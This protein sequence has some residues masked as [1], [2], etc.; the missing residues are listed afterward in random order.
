MEEIKFED[1]YGMVKLELI[2]KG[3]TDKGY[4]DTLELLMDT[5]LINNDFNELEKIDRL[6]EIVYIN[7]SLN[8][9]QLK[10]ID[11]ELGLDKYYEESIR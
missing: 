5:I 8:K 2:K 1:Y 9:K 3:K 6:R 10:N 4:F 7:G 11:K